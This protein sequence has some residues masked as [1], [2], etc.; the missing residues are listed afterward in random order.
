MSAV[1]RRASADARR[2]RDFLGRFEDPDD[3][4]VVEAQG[5]R[6][7][8]A[9][10]RTWIDFQ[11]GWGVGNLG[12]NPPEV[13]SRVHRFEG[14]SYV[15][16]GLSYAPWAELAE[17]LVTLAPGRIA[18]AYRV[19]TGTEAIE[20]ALQLAVA[21]TR[22]H[23][24]VSIEGAYHGN[25]FG[26]RSIGDGDLPHLPG[27][28][29]LGPPLDHRALARLETL[30]KHRDVAAFVMEPTITNLAVT[31]P[32]GAFMAG[33]TELC[34]RYGTLVIMDEIASGFGRTGRLFASEHYGVEP[35]IMTLAKSLGGGYAPIAATLATEEVASSA[36]GELEFFSTFGWQPLAVEAALATLDLWDARGAEMLANVA[37]R[38]EQI[39]SRVVAEFD[40]AELR[41]QG[42]AI[43]I[44]LGDEREVARIDGRCR[45]RGLLIFAEDGAL[46][47]LP[48]ITLDESTCAEA[49]EILAEARA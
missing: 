14:P 44:V 12:W 27:T 45:E 42:L 19:V 21:H 23:K 7:V 46:I 28:K 18:R 13:L 6:I 30:L 38:S 40:D 31:I 16:P 22:R 10:D 36:R 37:E 39:R 49:M 9:R 17:R 48:A 8:D 4:E 43:A 41:I 47:M 20:L 29:H 2:T 24:F 34:H 33:V 15:S 5:S 3:I 35:D 11:S 32:A 26:A 1:R 25:S